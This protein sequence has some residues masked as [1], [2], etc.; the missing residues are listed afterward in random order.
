MKFWIARSGSMQAVTRWGDL[1]NLA[2]RLEPKGVAVA[3]NEIDQ[4]LS[5]RSSCA[6]AKNALA[7]L[8]I[9]LALR[10]SLFSRSRAFMCSRSLGLR[11]S[12]EP[13]S[14]SCCLT[15]SLRVWGTQPILGAIDSMQAH[16]EGY[17]PLCSSTIRTERSR[18]SGEKRLDFLLFMAPSSQSKEPP[19]FPGRFT[20]N[21]SLHA[22]QAGIRPASTQSQPGPVISR[23]RADLSLSCVQYNIQIYTR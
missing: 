8:R 23:C 11:P 19:R 18:T 22:L 7:N 6:W 1:Q 2:Y 3:V 14:I 21:E 9:S 10:N 16:K 5:R 12:R 15:Q 4:D 13:V 17:S 20:Q